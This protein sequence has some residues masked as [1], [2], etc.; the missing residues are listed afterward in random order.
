MSASA[1]ILTPKEIIQARKTTVPVYD[2]EGLASFLQPK[3]DSTYVVNFWATWCIPCV[4]ELPYFEQL[5]EKYKGEKLKVILVSLDF[6]K[7]MDKS[8][9]PF[10][11]RKKLKSEVVLLDDKNANT[12]INQVDSSW[13]GALP[14]TLILNKKHRLFFEKSFTFEELENEY[15]K[16]KK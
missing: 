5:L 8:L 7:Q 13:S 1:Q 4:Q 15:L 11:V 10:M 14:A 9:I 12:W 2:F 3:G 6:R 16:S